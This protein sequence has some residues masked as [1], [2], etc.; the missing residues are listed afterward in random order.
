MRH[1]AA[2]MASQLIIAPPQVH[3]SEELLLCDVAGI[4]FV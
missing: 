1:V 3:E 2:A 4:T